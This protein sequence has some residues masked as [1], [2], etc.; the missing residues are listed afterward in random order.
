MSEMIEMYNYC[1]DMRDDYKAAAISTG[2][3]E[4]RANYYMYKTLAKA[5][6]REIEVMSR[7]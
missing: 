3:E 2:A 5:Y 1:C 7:E 4:D 6:E